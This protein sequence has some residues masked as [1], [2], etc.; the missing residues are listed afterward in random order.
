MY[1]RQGHYFLIGL[2]ERLYRFEM[3]KFWMSVLS[4]YF[5]TEFFSEKSGIAL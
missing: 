2:N 1:I 3:K 4:E 5:H